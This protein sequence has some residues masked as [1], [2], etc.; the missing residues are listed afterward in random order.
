MKTKKCEKEGCEK[1]LQQRQMM[2]KSNPSSKKGE[3][4]EINDILQPNVINYPI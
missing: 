2:R 4:Y 3:G 1:R